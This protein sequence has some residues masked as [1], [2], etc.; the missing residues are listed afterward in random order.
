M[1]Q[2]WFFQRGM[3]FELIVSVGLAAALL[4]LVSM[5]CGEL[6]YLRR[7]Y[8]AQTF[9]DDAIIG[10]AGGFI[11]WGLLYLQGRRQEFEAAR[12]RMRLTAEMNVHVRN[13]LA[14]MSNAVLT[15][16]QADRLR[17]MDEAIQRIDHVLNDLV[18]TMGQSTQTRLFN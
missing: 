9:F 17:L 18:P 10:A 2:K 4:F 6:L 13:A 14:I 11:V 7:I 5:A 12:E 15:Q 8:G 1:I 16:D 3:R